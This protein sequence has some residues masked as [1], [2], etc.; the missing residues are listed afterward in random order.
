MLRT[1]GAGILC[2]VFFGRC[3]QQVAPTGGKK[4][5][6]AP[7]L[8]QSMPLNKTL[9]FKGN[10]VELLF[11]EYVVI[12]NINSKLIITPA[13]E[14]PYT[15]KQN[16][17][18]VVLNFKKE[19][20]DNTTYTLNFGDA[21]KDFA[22]KNPAKNLKLVFSTGNSLDSGRVQG[23][24]KN[25]LSRKPLLDVLVGLYEI[26]DTLPITQQKP[27][28]FSRTDSSGYFSIENTNI[29]D[30]KLIAVEDKNRNMLYNTK[31][32]SIGFVT[33]SVNTGK[34]T[35]QFDINMFVSDIT[36]LKVQR[37][38]PKVNSYA[39][40]LNRNIED[41]EVRFPNNDSLPYLI[42]GG[43]QV[44][45]YKTESPSDTTYA[46]ITAIDSLGKKIELPLTK[47]AFQVPRGKDRVKD[48]FSLSAIPETNKPISK[49]VD[50]RITFN[51]PILKLE[52]SQVILITDSLTHQPLS[53]M[54]YSW[55]KYKNVLTIP[56]STIAQDTLKWELP[57]G[58]VISVEGDTLAQVVLKHPIMKGDD[59]GSL[60]GIIMDQDS[61]QH[62]IVELV[63]EQ[64]KVLQS[65][66]SSP[67]TFKN[68]PQGKYYLRLI[69]DE[70]ANKRWDTGDAQHNKQPETIIYLPD[71]MLIK[72]NFEL[73]DVNISAKGTK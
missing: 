65:A 73:N 41:L 11:D 38:L 25:I 23:Y 67:Y 45:F 28:Y 59:Y 48:P 51:K 16:G 6:L 46:Q 8:M 36:P 49:V 3:A 58:S 61:S 27:I 32:E 18:S 10:K 37:T 13:I 20:A 5:T 53:E 68:I 66:Y 56:F 50:Y 34:D 70:N 42:E 40:V 26:G 24:V 69:I 43:S 1:L 14:N 64:L 15:F 31:E 72:S 4:D 71:L 57:K 39:V 47:I 7:I 19:F 2:L 17:M 54:N 55:N 22:E 52:D 63:T 35:T 29:K 30:Y 21:I 12:D 9:N 33:N 62:Y 44:K 60:Q